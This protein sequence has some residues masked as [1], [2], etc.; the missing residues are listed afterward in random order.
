[1]SFFGGYPT[2]QP[3][4]I[5]ILVEVGCLRHHLPMHSLRRARSQQGAKFWVSKNPPDK[6]NSFCWS[7]RVQKEHNIIIIRNHHDQSSSL[8]INILLLLVLIKISVLPLECRLIQKNW[9]IRTCLRVEPYILNAITWK[10]SIGVQL[11]DSVDTKTGMWPKCGMLMD[12][13]Q[14]CGPS[15]NSNHQNIFWPY[16]EVSLSIWGFNN[17]QLWQLLQSP[18]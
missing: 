4:H 15:Y 2:K 5:K 14:S 9:G 3:F 8:M 6:E 13:V 11:V 1:M 7:A 16:K 18:T 10:M 17:H 12:A